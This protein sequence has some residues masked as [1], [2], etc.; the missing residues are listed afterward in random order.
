MSVE[1]DS[2]ILKRPEEVLNNPT[3]EEK[4]TPIVYLDDTL[5][6]Q[7]NIKYAVVG[8]A[9]ALI[10]TFAFIANKKQVI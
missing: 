10:A 3:I 4:S 5:K 1:I 2:M 6:N 9:F 7:K 8:L